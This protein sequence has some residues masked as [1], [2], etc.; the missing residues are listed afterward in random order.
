MLKRTIQLFLI[1]PFLSVSAN[2]DSGVDLHQ[3][4]MMKW[5]V[6][7]LLIGDFESP[8]GAK[9][10]DSKLGSKA[11]RETLATSKLGIV[12]VSLYAHPILVKK[13]AGGPGGIFESLDLQVKA[14]ENFV[15]QSNGEWII[16]KTAGEARAARAAGKKVFVLSIETA[17]GAVDTDEGIKKWI[18]EAGVRIVTFMHLTPDHLGGV[19]LWPGFGIF[20]APLAWIRSWIAGDKDEHGHYVNREGLSGSGKVL[21]EKLAQKKVWIDLAHSSDQTQK[22]TAEILDRYHQPAL[23]THTSS[24]ENLKG[25]RGIS[26]SQL[27]RVKETGGVIGLIVSETMM[28]PKMPADGSDPSCYRNFST[29]VEEWMRLSAKTS[30][31]Q[32]MLGSDFNAPLMGLS[33]GCDKTQDLDLVQ[34]GFFSAGQVPK[35]WSALRQMGAPLPIDL[36]EQERAF[37]DAWAKVNP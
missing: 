25:E 13:W 37:L 11:N 6:G 33:P 9:R 24:R 8:L 31:P 5:G 2:A 15:S 36:L 1:L 22:D 32:V 10:W 29:L 35:L 30:P 34:N 18:D 20:N 26:D 27:K 7:P 3:H 14:L 12:V 16:A 21:L 23:Y 17:A 19:A 4:L 28:E